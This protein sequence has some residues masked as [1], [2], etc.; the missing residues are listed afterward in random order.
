MNRGREKASLVEDYLNTAT[1]PLQM[2]FF[3]VFNSPNRFV[4]GDLLRKV[5]LTSHDLEGS[6][7]CDFCQYNR[8]ECKE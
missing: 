7:Q 1:L 4:Y 2:P 3:Y 5:G 6:S 8:V